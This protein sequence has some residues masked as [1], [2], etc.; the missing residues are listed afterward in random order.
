MPDTCT[1]PN[2]VKYLYRI[3]KGLDLDFHSFR[4]KK[5]ASGSSCEICRIFTPSKKEDGDSWLSPPQLALWIAKRCQTVGTDPQGPAVPTP[6]P[7]ALTALV[8]N[9]TSGNWTHSYHGTRSQLACVHYLFTVYCRFE[10]VTPII[11]LLELGGR[12]ELWILGLW[13]HWIYCHS[14]S[15]IFRPQDTTVFSLN[16]HSSKLT[17]T[18]HTFS[19]SLSHFHRSNTGTGTFLCIQFI[20]VSHRL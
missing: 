7:K 10:G 11:M 17:F 1:W 14:N 16:K 8:I 2:G 20:R 18:F 19:W 9:T 13:Q 15:L 4:H 5:R 12:Q 3:Y 6:W